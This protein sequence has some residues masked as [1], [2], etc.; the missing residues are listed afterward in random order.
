MSTDEFLIV[1]LGASAGGIKAFKEF[2]E[3]VPADSGMSYVVVLHLSPEHDSH[4]AEVLQV[5]ASIPVTQVRERVR[6]QPNHVYV[7]PPNQS[8]SMPDGHLGVSNVTRIEERRAPVDIFFRTLAESRHSFAACV[9]LSGTGA[10]GSMGLKRVK[11]LG[12]ICVV[13]D[14]DEAEFSDMPRNSIATALVDHVLPVK[15]IPAKLIAYR[16]SLAT[17]P[18]EIEEPDRVID[19]Q[20]LRELFGHLRA[21]TGHDFANYKRATVLR[22]VHRRMGVHQILDLGTYAQYVR[23]Q[24]KEAQAL[25]KDLLISVTNFFR[26]RDAFGSLERVVL[27]KLFQSKTENDQVRAWVAGCATGEEAY[28]LAMLLA[29][30]SAGVPG[31]PMVQ[32]FA[33]D[34]D[35]DAIAMAREGV[36]TINDAADVP[37]ERLRRFFQKE[38]DAYRVRK[39]L[40]EMVLFAHHNII[41]DPPFSHL[42]LVS[43]RN[44][45]IY[46][47]RSAQ[48]RVMEV[49]HFALKPEGYLFLGSTES[50]EG[51]GD[52]FVVVDKDARIFESRA[53][54]A[55][56]SIPIGVLAPN[57]RR[58]LHQAGEARTKERLSFADLHLR[59]LEQY[60]PP[61]MVVNEDH[62]IVHVSESAGRFLQFVGGEPSHDLL[63]VVRPELRLELRAALHQSAQQRT[64]VTVSDLTVRLDNETVSVDIIVRPVL[65]P[66]DTAQG[67]FLIIFQERQRGIDDAAAAPANTIPAPARQIDAAR[68][69]EDE[70]IR[71]KATLRTTIERD[72]TQAEELKASNEELQAMNEELRSSTEEL[73]TSKEELQSLNE[74][75]RTVNQELKIKIEEQIQANDDIHNLINSAEIGTVF[76]DR[77][78]RVKM[79]TPRT[80]DIFSLL[81]IDRGR[82]LE[83]INNHLLVTDLTA[84]IDRVL[85][86]EERVEREVQTR[87]GRWF[88]M[89]L[90]PYRNL[91][92]DHIDGV[93]L[94]FFE[95][96]VRK[97]AEEALRRSEERMR[98]V[99][100]SVADYAILTLDEEGRIDT[101]TAGA[102][103]MFGF[104]EPEAIGS[105]FDL[106]ST[107]EDR[108]SGV[109][110]AELRQARVAGRAVV[111][112]W[113]MRKDGTRVFVSGTLSPLRSAHGVI[114]GYVKIARD[115]TEHK[116]LE[117]AL[118]HANDD[119][120]ARVNERTRELADANVTLDLELRE[121]RGAEE[122]IRR[123]LNRLVTIQEDERRRVARDLHD[124]LGQQI[125]AL[126]LT[127]ESLK[128]ASMVDGR[129]PETVA[130]AQ[131]ITERLDRD[132]D[133][134]TSE[135]RPPAIDDLGLGTALAQYV[136][137]W[138]RNT[139]VPAQ[140]QSSALDGLHLT[141]DLEINLYRIAQEGLNNVYKHA[142]AT[143]V[144]VFL[145][146]RDGQVVLIV[147][148]NGRGFQH[149]QS[150]GETRD[151]GLGLLGMRE[152]AALMGGQVEIETDP[153]NGT[154]IFVKVPAS[155]KQPE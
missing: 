153:G 121:R 61:S 27:P 102:R 16:N 65:R 9:V 54:S 115:L 49:T 53:T 149:P 135:L 89:R 13:Q 14:P 128:S 50:I 132:L 87:D 21:G 24:P 101:W 79:F 36:Y 98:L 107:F 127:L 35:V 109:A 28:S 46:L 104:T 114:L 60:A 66:T 150:A 41:K 145:G 17:L 91:A 146:R 22:R 29:E 62:E 82:Q 96:T 85:Q 52:L 67:F 119:L 10:D 26:D 100:E 133:F 68:Q 12:G 88:M 148:D 33:T 74:E 64:N 103:A 63:R 154:S 93:V 110:A 59:L 38:G 57:E 126:R 134:F 151:R 48:R 84:D 141:S 81:P 124:H 18:I 37:V 140:F 142:Q 45:L 70:V 20:S 90:I 120:D 8:L 47:N 106:L 40:R 32:I 44:L 1:G 3:H 83:D 80:R 112:R 139:G 69:L 72:E 99:L 137:E 125:T 122:R 155:F 6:I 94:T 105:S 58:V 95:I 76:L 51:S 130:E 19:E 7:V 43:C 92:E 108:E 123:L 42:D 15:A 25:L 78:S 152:R 116:R 129:L 143:L 71:L 86:H 73:E 5:S 23:E 55:R 4:L 144:D 30:H 138:S 39:E 77:S 97:L 111:A 56:I 2:F 117:D 113:H 136:A 131:R 34:I 11:E 147:E 75:M 31:A 118:H